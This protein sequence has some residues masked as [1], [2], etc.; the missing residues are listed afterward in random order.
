MRAARAVTTVVALVLAGCA[1]TTPNTQ[2][3][4]AAQPAPASPSAS[5]PAATS[6]APASA[7][8]VPGDWTPPADVAAAARNAGLAML[9]EEKL[10][11]H[12]HAHLDVIVDGRP[13]PVPAGL[14]IDETRHLIAPLHTHDGTGI[15]HI[16]SATD[17]PFTLGQIFSEWGQPLRSDRVGPVTLAPGRE[18]R[19]YRNG[20]PVSGDPA[21]LRLG[22]HDE[23]A[24]WVGAPGQ[25]PTVPTGYRFPPGY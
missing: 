18:L 2:R 11:V 13:V 17:V 22:A 19:V 16:E 7:A 14:G 15:V 6:A 1:G 4:A 3:S 23:I 10:T 9:G 20:Q 12:Y 24:V 8:P 25:Q 21:A 5:A